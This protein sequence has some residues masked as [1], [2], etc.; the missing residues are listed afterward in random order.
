MMSSIVL[1]TRV[2]L[3]VG[4]ISVMCACAGAASTGKPSASAAKPVEPA[5][6]APGPT[7]ASATDSPVPQPASDEAAITRFYRGKTIRIIV[8]TPPGGGFDIYARLISRHVR[9]Y[10]PGNPT[11]VV[12]N[13]AGA[14]TAVAA[15]YVY[16]LAP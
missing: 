9:K 11:V 3:L 4:A 12:E 1:H 8:G 2:T 13:M 16:N 6:G 10:I 7:I 5:T 15:N 14:G